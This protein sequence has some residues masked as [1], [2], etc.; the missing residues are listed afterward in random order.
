[1]GNLN[2]AIIY[3]TKS[4]LKIEVASLLNLRV[5]FGCGAGFEPATFGS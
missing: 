4:H 1:M 5:F 2:V 3:N